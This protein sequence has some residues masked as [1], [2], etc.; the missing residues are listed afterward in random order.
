[1]NAIVDTQVDRKSDRAQSL[2]KGLLVL[3]SFSG[4]KTS[5]TL[6]DVARAAGMNRATT[7][8]FLLTLVDLGYLET[9]GKLYTLTPK[10]MTLGYN[11][12]SSLPWW[13]LAN[14]IVDE[15][16][17]TLQES[18]AVAVLSSDQLTFVTRVQGPRLVGANLMPGR[19]LPVH[20]TATGRVLLAELPAAEID[21]FISR[22]PLV[23]HTEYTVTDPELLKSALRQAREQGYAIVDQELEIGLRAIGVPVRNA[24]GQLIA[25]VGVST[26]SHRIPIAELE[27]RILPVIR[28]G[29]A[30]L[31]N[32][33]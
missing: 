28:T 3:Q 11:Y 23:P 26:Q 32:V 27:Q 14:P 15:I 29:I 13:Q 6:S 20:A 7:R 10:V 33:L 25:A 4:G 8:R 9:D 31:R 21:A 1:M 5:M 24:S 30:K 16:S 19:S 12:L 22:N 17:R 18:C 2:Y